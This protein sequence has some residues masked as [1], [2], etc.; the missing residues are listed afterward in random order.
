MPVREQ[1]FGLLDRQDEV[2]VNAFPVIWPDPCMGAE[3]HVTDHLLGGM[4]GRHAR[5]KVK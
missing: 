3:A 2:L 4:L 5:A 1:H